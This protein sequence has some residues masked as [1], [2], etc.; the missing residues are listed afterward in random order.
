[1][2]KIKMSYTISSTIT[3]L[4]PYD[5][6]SLPSLG[7][8]CWNYGGMIVN[9]PPRTYTT[10]VMYHLTRVA[11]GKVDD[12]KI[13]DTKVDV[14]SIIR[15]VES[16]KKTNDDLQKE[17]ISLKQENERLLNIIRSIDVK[18]A[19]KTPTKP[20]ENTESQSKQ[21]VSVT[22]CQDP[23]VCVEKK[24]DAQVLVGHE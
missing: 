3:G 8:D 4:Y 20:L 23:D 6:I 17:V 16:L 14:D 11:E 21:D 1:M 13:N 24:P 7:L 2:N 5:N 9:I 18:L 12:M 10:P 22:D 19:D 15:A